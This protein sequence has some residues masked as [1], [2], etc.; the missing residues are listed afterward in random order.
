VLHTASMFDEHPVKLALMGQMGEEGK[1]TVA[2]IIG[3]VPS[4]MEGV[5]PLK[6]LGL[7]SGKVLSTRGLNPYA[8]AGDLAKLVQGLTVGGSTQGG[9]D[10]AS[11]LSPFLTSPIERITGHK[12][13][14]D[15]PVS[16]SGAL[17]PSTLMDVI[18]SVSEIKL[19]KT[20]IEGTQRPHPNSRTGKVTPFLNGKGPLSQAEG[21][22]G[23]PIKD[24]NLTRAH[25]LA[26]KELGI[27]KKKKRKVHHGLF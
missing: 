18:N 14:T 8:S 27:H 19:G 9:A 4:Y 15:V 21:L 2:N 5:V 16:K 22:L 25:E 1:D 6:M 7:G 12:I 3:H 13:G 11:G 17:I 23:V 24:V 20:L 26:N 10:I